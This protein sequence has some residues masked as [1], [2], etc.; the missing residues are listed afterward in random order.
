LRYHGIIECLGVSLGAVA[1]SP[2]VWL[3]LTLVGLNGIGFFML[4]V[5]ATALLVV[6]YA[7]EAYWHGMFVVLLL[8]PV[9]SMSAINDNEV[10]FLSW[11]LLLCYTLSLIAFYIHCIR[12]NRAAHEALA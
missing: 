1:F 9:H 11:V 5:L 8:Q 12:S 7:E 3:G 10:T 6:L 4:P 2:S